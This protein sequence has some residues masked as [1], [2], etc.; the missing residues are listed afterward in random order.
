MREKERAG[1]SGSR[2]T[3]GLLVNS[4]TDPRDQLVW[5]AAVETAQSL[6]ANLVCFP[7]GNPSGPASPLYELIGPETLDG[8][9][10]Q[11]Y[12]NQDSFH[13]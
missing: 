6:D 7:V 3:I 1:W 13:F 10:F 11:L 9:I 12:T 4:L 2:P 5:T 8:L